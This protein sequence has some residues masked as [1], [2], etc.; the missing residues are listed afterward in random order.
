MKAMPFASSSITIRPTFFLFLGLLVFASCQSNQKANQPGNKNSESTDS[1]GIVKARE[2]NGPTLEEDST[3]SDYENFFLVVAD[4]G[5]DYYLLRKKMFILTQKFD[6]PVD[7]MG[8]GYYPGKKLI[9]LP[10]NDEDEMYAGSYFPRR[11][12]SESLSLEYL[13]FYRQSADEKTIA[14]LAGI[15][16]KEEE[17]QARLQL[18]KGVQ[19]SAFLFQAKVFTG[20]MH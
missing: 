14:L 15:F 12:P 18:I 5:L 11:F 20:C 7:T 17:A 1:S 16:E 13:N 9:A 2:A 6:I 3:F 8:R 19:Q 10:E 4:T